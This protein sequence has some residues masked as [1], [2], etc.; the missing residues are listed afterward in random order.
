MN[1]FAKYSDPLFGVLTLA[2]VICLLMRQYVAAEGLVIISCFPAAV[3]FLELKSMPKAEVMRMV[4]FW[5]LFASAI[6]VLFIS[7]LENAK[8]LLLFI[9]CLSFAI[10]IARGGDDIE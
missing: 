1:K 8:W 5:I 9:A 7:I 4:T 6:V 3:Y 10:Y 2:A